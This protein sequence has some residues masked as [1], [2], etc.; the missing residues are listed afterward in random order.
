MHYVCIE[1]QRVVSVVNYEPSVPSTVSVMEI[2]QA[3]F[4]AVQN[5]ELAVDPVAR[6]LIPLEP[7]TT[8]VSSTNNQV[9]L[10]F[11]DSTDWQVLRHIREQA[12]GVPTTL[13]QEQYIDLEQQRQL[14]AASVR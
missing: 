1:N 4:D 3:E 10:S 8:K 7:D 14:A 9:H 12:L 13:T 5:G 6:A 11:L 2:S